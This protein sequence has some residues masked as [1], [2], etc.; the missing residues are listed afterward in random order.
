MTSRDLFVVGVRVVGLLQLAKALDY[1]VQAFDMSSGL[2]KLSY[3]SIGACYTHILV[4]LAVG[5]YLVSGAPHFVRKVLDR[6]RGDS[7]EQDRDENGK[8]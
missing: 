7:T 3:M 4:Y 2:T 8:A 6:P 5:L 1:L